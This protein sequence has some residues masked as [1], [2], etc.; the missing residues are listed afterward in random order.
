MSSHLTSESQFD[1]QV[2]IPAIISITTTMLGV[3]IVFSP[4][5]EQHFDHNLCTPHR[6]TTFEY[7]IS[8][9]RLRPSI[10]ALQIGYPSIASEVMSLQINQQS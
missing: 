7:G 3:G 10:P 4:K 5:C 8:Y 1:D 2:Y 9:N 6:I